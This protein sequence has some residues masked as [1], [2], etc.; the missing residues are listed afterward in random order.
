VGAKVY[1]WKEKPLAGSL[2]HASMSFSDETGDTY[3]SAWP[4]SA[5]RSHQRE[6]GKNHSLGTIL[7]R[8][9]WLE[10]YD[11]DRMLMGGSVHADGEVS[12]GNADVV[13]DIAGFD[14]RSI[15]RGLEKVKSSIYGDLF[16]A[17]GRNC[18]FIVGMTLTWALH[19]ETGH[20]ANADFGAFL[21]LIF[22]RAAVPVG[23]VLGGDVEVICSNLSNAVIWSP[24]GL[25][26]H[27]DMLNKIL[28]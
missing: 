18:C 22:K 8:V 15:R 11:H 1:I 2:G 24:S 14:G 5:F 7:G 13:K 27:V 19:Y 25:E 28:D 17:T 12:G 3:V 6:G 10:Q 20:R 9:R 4:A 23:T 21:G 16:S 26:S